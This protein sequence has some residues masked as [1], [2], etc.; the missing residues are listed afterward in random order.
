[1]K[2]YIDFIHFIILIVC[3]YMYLTPSICLA[4]SKE[5]IKEIAVVVN[6]KNPIVSLTSKQVSDIF[7][8]RRRTFPSGGAVMVLEQ[9]RDGAIREK[10]FN[11]LNGMNL[12]RLNAYWTR[13]QFSG[14]IQPP[15]V[16]SD[17]VA[18]KNAVKDNINAIGYLPS[19]YVDESVRVVLI[20][21]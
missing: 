17:S 9:E 13:L 1:M 19:Q 11:L 18:V 7:L 10:F 20:L 8:S 4:D 2:R 15:P 12:K 5:D 14:E 3:C 21:K 16:M 6:S